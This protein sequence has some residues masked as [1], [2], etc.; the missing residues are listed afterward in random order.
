MAGCTD[1][2]QQEETK[3]TISRLRII[4]IKW[5]CA[6]ACLQAITDE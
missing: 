1:R 3:T 6:H 5:L 4:T 2:E